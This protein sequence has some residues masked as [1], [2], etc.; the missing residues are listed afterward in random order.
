MYDCTELS[1]E[2]LCASTSRFTVWVLENPEKKKVKKKYSNL[3]SSPLNSEVKML[4]LSWPYRAHC[5]AKDHSG[6]KVRDPT[7]AD[8]EMTSMKT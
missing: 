2:V 6:F 7:P 1:R 3:S 5:L 4:H 8:L